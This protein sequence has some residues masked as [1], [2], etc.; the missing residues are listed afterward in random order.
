MIG[1]L[2]RLGLPGWGAKLLGYVAVPLIAAGLLYLAVTAYGSARYDAGVAA[3]KAAELARQQ[4]A[5]LAQ[6]KREATA[7]TN[8]GQQKARDV[9]A[10]QDRQQE[11]DNATNALPD[12]A[13]SARQ[14]TRA[15][16][17]LRRQA[18]AAGRSEPAC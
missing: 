4:A 9:A 5:E 16:L 11:I 7:T 13:P 1:F 6:R 14:R 10:S 12:Q 2:L 8:L 3:E 18:K 15:C 17:E